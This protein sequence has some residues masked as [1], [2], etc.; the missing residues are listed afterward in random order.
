MESDSL[1]YW[2]ALSR[3]KG[4]ERFAINGIIERFGPPEA[5]FRET[6]KGLEAFS[7]AFAKS[8]AG[9][10]DW[11]RVDKELALIESQGVT[12]ITFES[13]LYPALLK[14]IYDPPCVLYAK[15]EASFEG[16]S[17]AVV[18]TRHPTH[19]GLKMSES[20]SRDLGGM[21][22]TVVSGMARGCDMAAHK[23]ALSSG[24]F[25]VAVL[26]TGVDTPYPREN[27][28]LYEEI[29]E[30]GLVISEFP[31][32][33]PPLPQN[34][35]RRNRIISGLSEGVLVVEAP[36]RSGSLMTAGLALEYNR[37]VFAV[38]GP[39]TSPKSM[40]ANK[41]LK[42]GARLVESAEDITEA[43]GLKFTPRTKKEALPGMGE[44]EKLVW[45]SLG[46]EPV[47]IDGIVER[48]GLPVSRASS[49]LL[50]MELKGL[51]QQRPGKCFLRRF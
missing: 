20:I 27:K 45:D 42:Q 22:V 36:L 28:K 1:K 14:E 18:G 8:V 10:E 30:K 37:E 2:L 43:L 17:V 26:G 29:I 11:K 25:T 13:P 41:L 23:G 6:R 4:I 24:G 15:G 12:I 16:P 34:F 33:T 32:G 50:E 3:L 46:T 48:T 19:Y 49:L 51:V 47:H 39:V 21:G 7:A 5:I 44:E 35:P 31:L 40:G 9:F 38:P